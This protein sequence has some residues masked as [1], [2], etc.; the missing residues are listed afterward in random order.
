MV[1]DAFASIGTFSLRAN[2]AVNKK[3]RQQL[4]VL[5]LQIF[6]S[7]CKA[8]NKPVRDVVHN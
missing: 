8:A 7:Q 3:F 4:G 2:S 6:Q 1:R 5:L